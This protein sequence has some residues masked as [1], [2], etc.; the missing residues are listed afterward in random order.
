MGLDMMAYKVRIDKVGCH[1]TQLPEGYDKG[2]EELAYWRKHPNLQ[3][4]MEKLW[5]AKMRKSG[6]EIPSRP[7][8][9][10]SGMSIF[11]CIPVRVDEDDLRRLEKAVLADALPFA[12]GFFWGVSRPEHK[13]LDLK[14]IAKARQAIADGYAVIYDSSW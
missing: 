3:G 11:N 5:E 7:V 14:F 1:H 9:Q 2:Q 13:E 4:W 6:R 12:S 10:F 8:G